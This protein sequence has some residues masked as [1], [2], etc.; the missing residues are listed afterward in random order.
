MMC[1]MTIFDTAFFK[2][3]KQTGGRRSCVTKT[4]Y[5]CFYDKQADKDCTALQDCESCTWN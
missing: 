2:S 4:L 1:E 3:V 5:F